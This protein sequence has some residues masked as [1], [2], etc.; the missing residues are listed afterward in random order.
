[1][2]LLCL[3]SLGLSEPSLRGPSVACEVEVRTVDGRKASFPL[4][5]R[6]E[7]EIDRR[8][9]PLL[10]LACAQPLL[11]YGLFAERI[12]LGFP[13]SLADRELLVHLNQVFSRDI[14]VN[15]ILRRRTSYLLPEYVPD[16][17]QVTP[18]HAHPRAGIIPLATYDDEAI[19]SGGRPG[20]CGVLSSGGK[21][22]L[23]T[24]GLLQEM[25]AETH[26]LYVNESGGHWRTAL[27]AYRH[28][29]S[30][31][32]HTARVWTNVDRFYT[33][34][35]DHLACIRA[36]HRRVR[37]DTYPIRLCIFPFYVFALL[38][39]FARRRLGNL[40]IGSEFDDFREQ[41]THLGIPHY[42]GVYDQHQDYDLCMNAW[43]A[44]RMP[45]L[46]QWS[47]LR[48]VTGLVV[49]RIL[50]RRY[51]QLA[52]LQRSCHSC[53]LENGAVV[54]CGTCSKCRG[55][56]LFLLANE[57]DPA[58]M[59]FRRSQ[60]A[61]FCHHLD[62]RELR[63]DPD[64]KQHALYLLCGRESPLPPRPVPHVEQIHLDPDICDPGLV[65][66]QFRKKLFSILEQYTH[67]YCHLENGRWV[68]R[69][70]PP[71]VTPAP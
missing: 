38:P 71:E 14:F 25:G 28:H 15:K 64:E 53:H 27:V 51:P 31:Q 32:P 5:L 60:V 59:A 33:F 16:E 54:P 45:G 10:R 21:E 52:T 66:A 29:R 6:Y 62:P 69:P 23:L 22:S 17:R 63:L 65:P 57:G 58:S 20:A 43:Y 70:P 9:L 42:Y 26:P 46:R 3:E 19:S 36:D 68:P 47:A 61:D 12:H 24:Y 7:E 41:P 11:N 67:G 34:M 48:S 13:L 50:T 35:L 55:V 18:D 49:E 1:M 8:H 4:R 44:R 2:N 39:L 56:L 40:L 30:R 37:A